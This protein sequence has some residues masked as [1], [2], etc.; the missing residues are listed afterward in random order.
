MELE[1]TDRHEIR[2]RTLLEDLVSKR[3]GE[4]LNIEWVA[5][6]TLAASSYLHSKL[7]AEQ[8][9]HLLPGI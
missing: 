5:V 3:A 1:H 9:E 7:Y 2:L 4:G 8:L 6:R